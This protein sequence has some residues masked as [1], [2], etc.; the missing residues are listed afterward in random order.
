MILM[1]FLSIFKL[2]NAISGAE[3]QR[4]PKGICRVRTL[5]SKQRKVGRKESALSRRVKDFSACHLLFGASNWKKRGAS[6][7]WQI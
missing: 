3:T 4:Q 1:S 7:A 5:G 2:F 6:E